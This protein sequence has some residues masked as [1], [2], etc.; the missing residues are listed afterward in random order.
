MRAKH[1]KKKNKKILAK[2]A[3]SFYPY[4]D[5]A[6]AKRWALLVEK[7]NDEPKNRTSNTDYDKWMNLND[8]SEEDFEYQRSYYVP[9]FLCYNT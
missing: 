3:K 2:L 4:T 1:E 5:K 7:I 9:P 6:T 8:P